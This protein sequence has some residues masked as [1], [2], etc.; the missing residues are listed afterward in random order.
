[1]P[2]GKLRFQVAFDKRAAAAD[3][4]YGSKP[5][6]WVEQFRRS[7][8]I[9]YL[10]GGEQVIEQRM[11]GVVPAVL[12]VRVDS[13]TRLI[14]NSWRARD[15]ASGASYNLR[16]VPP[17]DGKPLYMDFLCSTGTADG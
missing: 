6:D 7:C 5:G 16:A 12:T 8:G 11:A 3:G 1:M 10:R 14:D 13:Q 4:G 17:D 2:A 9:Q 15:L